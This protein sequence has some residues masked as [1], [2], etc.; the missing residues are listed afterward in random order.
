MLRLLAVAAIS[1]ILAVA[2]TGCS[3]DSV[4]ETEPDEPSLRE[5]VSGFWEEMQNDEPLRAYVIFGS[6]AYKESCGPG[7]FAPSLSQIDALLG[8]GWRDADLRIESVEIDGIRGTV[9]SDFYVNDSPL[10]FGGGRL[11]D[12]IHEK[13]R[14]RFTND[15][16]GPCSVAN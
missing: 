9:V 14:W 4:G 12:W 5:A 3:S 7:E 6:D 13:G 8:G 15:A 2:L 11:D 16:P 1:I 10:G